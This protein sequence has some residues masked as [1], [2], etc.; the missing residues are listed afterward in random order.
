MFSGALSSSLRFSSG[1]GQTLP[2]AQRLKLPTAMGMVM[3]ED[4][5]SVLVVIYSGFLARVLRIISPQGWRLGNC[6]LRKEW[7]QRGY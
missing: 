2:L 3:A 1:E 6:S 7:V 5:K 4:V